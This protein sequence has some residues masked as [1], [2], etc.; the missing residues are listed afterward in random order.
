MG[1]YYRKQNRGIYQSI[2]EQHNQLGGDPYSASP[3]MR[4]TLEDRK[5]AVDILLAPANFENNEINVEGI[6]LSDSLLR[7]LGIE[8]TENANNI[9]VPE[10]P[11][12]EQ[13]PAGINI[14][15]LGLSEELLN[16]LKEL[17]KEVQA[18]N[19]NAPEQQQNIGKP[20]EN[21]E[22]VFDP[23]EFGQDKNADEIDL[24]GDEM[25][26]DNFFDGDEI[27]NE[28]GGLVNGGEPEV[29]DENRRIKNEALQNIPAMDVMEPQ[30]QVFDYNEEEK[31]NV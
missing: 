9:N 18:Q 4:L 1:Y 30:D 13:M 19:N 11:K 28:L 25:I 22:M 26:G 27:N 3:N 10:P 21:D 23:N 2:K 6:G 5:K 8:K 16:D 15:D 14:D 20:K 24:D 17:K 29:Q 31:I 12:E 7:D